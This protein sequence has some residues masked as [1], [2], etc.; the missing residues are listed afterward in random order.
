MRRIPTRRPLPAA[1]LA[2]AALLGLAPGAAADPA[3]TAGAVRITQ[4]DGVVLPVG[5]DIASVL[6]ADPGIADV[7]PLSNRTLFLFGK[8][9]GT[10]RLFVLDEGDRIVLERR[11]VVTRALHELARAARLASGG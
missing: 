7:Q 10:T 9:E 11:V 8:A 1:A 2:A 3:A 6:I 5:R 4:S